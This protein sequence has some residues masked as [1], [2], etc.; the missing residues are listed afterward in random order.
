M[1][2]LQLQR[3]AIDDYTD[4]HPENITDEFPQPVNA[5]NFKSEGIIYSR[6][7]KKLHHTYAIFKHVSCEELMNM[8]KLELFLI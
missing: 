6:W 3:I 4:P 5:Y 1:E 2:D 8:K 7:S